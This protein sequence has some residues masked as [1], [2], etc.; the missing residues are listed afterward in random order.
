MI[1]WQKKVVINYL[2][3]DGTANVTGHL[4]VGDAG[5]TQLPNSIAQFTGTSSTYAQVNAQNLDG[6]GTTDIVLT[7]DTW[8]RHWLHSRPASV[9]LAL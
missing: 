8:P 7:A 6:H 3:V 1:E 5:Y 9:G 4:S 2:I